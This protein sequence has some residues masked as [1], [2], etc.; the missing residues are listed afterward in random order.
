[1]KDPEPSLEADALPLADAPLSDVR[2]P[3]GLTAAELRAFLGLPATQARIRAVVVARVKGKAP[4]ALIEDLV[5]QANVDALTASSRPRSMATAMGWLGTLTARAVVNHFRRDAV[6]A[7]YLEP[8]VDLDELP[9]GPDEPISSAPEWLLTDWLRPRVAGNPRE[10][11]TY[12]LLVYK[13]KTGKTHAQVAT[14]HGMT[15]GALKSRIRALKMK[16]EPQWRR[17][18]RTFILLILA[19]VAAAIAVIAWLLWP[20]H[21]DPLGSSPP[22]TAPLIERAFGRDLPV[23]HGRPRED[24]DGGRP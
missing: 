5:Q 10:Q 2:L 23:G 4:G 19:G 7:R 6:H 9:S 21:H 13:A 15:E 12:E 16:Y 3:T 8:E 22:A 17:R 14:D 20:S 24:A 18:Q 11:E 1:M